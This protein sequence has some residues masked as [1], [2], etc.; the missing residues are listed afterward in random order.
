MA[1]PTPT[2]A[3]IQESCVLQCAASE[4]ILPCSSTQPLLLSSPSL[5]PLP[6]DT[7]DFICSPTILIAVGEGTSQQDFFVHETLLSARSEFFARLLQGPWK[8]TNER[9]V[10]LPEDEPEVVKIWLKSLY[11]RCSHSNLTVICCY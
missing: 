1:S 7:A 5:S 10:S 4:S 6:T 8:E 11:V 3:A 2:P 9:R